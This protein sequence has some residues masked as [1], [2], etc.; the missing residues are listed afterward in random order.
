MHKKV[1][2]KKNAEAT[3]SG[4]TAYHKKLVNKA[5]DAAFEELKLV[6]IRTDHE[7]RDI[8]M[9]LHEKT[10]KISLDVFAA[11]VYERALRRIEKNKQL[12]GELRVE[13]NAKERETP[14]HML[15]RTETETRLYLT[16]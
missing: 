5:L 4:A 1:N 11:V 12:I 2:S 3:T 7:V 9:R 13:T 10:G 8:E 6:P 14:P 15:L 16:P